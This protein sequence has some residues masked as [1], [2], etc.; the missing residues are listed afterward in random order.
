[1]VVPPLFQ[2]ENMGVYDSTEIP[3]EVCLT[4]GK[5]RNQEIM[6][7]GENNFQKFPFKQ[8]IRGPGLSPEIVRSLGFCA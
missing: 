3:L 2:S 6:V 8:G 4:S 1:M 7:Q 5:W